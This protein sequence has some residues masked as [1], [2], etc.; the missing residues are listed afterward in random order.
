MKIKK[1]AHLRS[2][3]AKPGLK[4]FLTYNLPAKRFDPVILG[5]SESPYKNAPIHTDFIQFGPI[6]MTFHENF[7]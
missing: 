5:P 1:F 3:N 7:L 4:Q 2:T 6:F